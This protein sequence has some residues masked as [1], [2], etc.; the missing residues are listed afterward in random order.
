MCWRID[1]RVRFTLS[2]FSLL[3]CWAQTRNRNIKNK[4]SKTRSCRSARVSSW[5]SI[6]TWIDLYMADMATLM[7]NEVSFVYSLMMTTGFYLQLLG[8]TTEMDKTASYHKRRDISSAS[9]WYSIKKANAVS[10]L[11]PSGT[12]TNHWACEPQQVIHSR[13]YIS[14]PYD[15]IVNKRD[16]NLTRG[17]KR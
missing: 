6:Q 17:M 4:S 16:K 15:A 11:V 14:T 2:F 3:S 8:S 5:E 7:H 1:K 9:T 13:H 12:S 10:R